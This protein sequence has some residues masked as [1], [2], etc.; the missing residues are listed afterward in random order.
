[1]HLNDFFSFP[2]SFSAVSYLLTRICQTTRVLHD[3][4]SARD[5]TSVK[6]HQSTPSLSF[7]TVLLSR[8]TVLPIHIPTCVTTYVADPVLPEIAASQEGYSTRLLANAF[9]IFSLI[10]SVLSCW[11]ILRSMPELSF[12]K[13]SLSLIPALVTMAAVVASS[14][15]RALTGVGWP[16]KNR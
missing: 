5:T 9:A 1:M 12:Q 7:S 6:R 16:P 14:L 4:L 10:H 15:V 2:S 13:I 8:C 3:T 11:H